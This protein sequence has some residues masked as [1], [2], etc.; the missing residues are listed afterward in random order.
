M[1]VGVPQGQFQVIFLVFDH[2]TY[3][4]LPSTLPGT[5]QLKCFNEQIFHYITGMEETSASI[6]GQATRWWWLQ[7][8]FHHLIFVYSWLVIKFLCRLI[9]WQICVE[10]ST[11]TAYNGRDCSVC[12]LLATLQWMITTTTWVLFSRLFCVSMRHVYTELCAEMSMIHSYIT[13]FVVC[14]HC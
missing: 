10:T 8:T 14:H 6:P 5:S 2:Q 13:S 11:N 3:P 1:H 7:Y 4:R 12:K 9:G